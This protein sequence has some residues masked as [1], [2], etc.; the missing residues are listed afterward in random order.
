MS[1]FMTLD[2]MLAPYE[3]ERLAKVRAEMAAEKAAW[4]ALPQSEK[5]RILAE[6]EKKWE[7][8]DAACQRSESEQEDD[9]DDEEDD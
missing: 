4:D 3:E 7:D 1:K 9:E 5:D 8:F 6:N 2:E